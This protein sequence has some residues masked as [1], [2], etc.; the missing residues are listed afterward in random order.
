MGNGTPTVAQGD[1]SVL[2]PLQALSKKL[3]CE[4]ALQVG[5]Q[6]EVTY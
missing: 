4:V 6:L 1:N 3:L 5:Q 2:A